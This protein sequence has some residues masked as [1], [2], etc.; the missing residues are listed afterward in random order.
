MGSYTWKKRQT[1]G[2]LVTYSEMNLKRGSLDEVCP[3]AFHQ[4]PPALLG[5]AGYQG[6]GGPAVDRCL[7]SELQGALITCWRSRAQIVGLIYSWRCG[8]GRLCPSTWA[9]LQLAF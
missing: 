8:W 5:K 2:L 1:P 4:H 9:L 6:A 3:K 7:Q